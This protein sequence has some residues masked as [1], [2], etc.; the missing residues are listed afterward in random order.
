[1]NWDAELYLRACNF[2]SHAHRGQKV[3]GADEPYLRHVV[4]VAA[5]VMAAIAQRE[6]VTAPDLAVACALLH[7]AVEDTAVSEREIED[8]FGP[9]VAAGVAALTKNAALGSKKAQ[10]DDSLERILLQPHEVWMVKMAD[11]IT[12]LQIPPPHWT[13]DK[14]KG[15]RLQA[16]TIHD[17]LQAACPIL[18]AR[19]TR[20]I[21]AYP[22]P[23]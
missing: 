3:P 20:K 9:G 23:R 22:P 8:A 10:M 1:M 14:I 19:L 4:C 12:N 16:Q 2:A 6:D 18:A 5:E 7:D 11:R 13:D 21:E 15:Y 17:K